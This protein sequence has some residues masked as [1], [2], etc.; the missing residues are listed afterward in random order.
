MSWSA[1]PTY[2]KKAGEIANFA[3]KIGGYDELIRLERERR[4]IQSQGG[5]PMVVQD[6]QGIYRVIAKPE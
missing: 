1:T 5:K 6:P 3:R 4:E 2:L